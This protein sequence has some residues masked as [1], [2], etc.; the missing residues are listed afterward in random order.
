MLAEADG[1][2]IGEMSE[3]QRLM[4]LIALNAADALKAA[5]G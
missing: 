3:D 1:K 2:P 4:V 5:H